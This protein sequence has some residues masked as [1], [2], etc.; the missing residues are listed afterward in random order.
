ML[1]WKASLII[2]STSLFKGGVVIACIEIAF[3]R[4]SNMTPGFFQSAKFQ[5]QIDIFSETSVIKNRTL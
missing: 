2:F 3:A 5:Q 1:H 4:K